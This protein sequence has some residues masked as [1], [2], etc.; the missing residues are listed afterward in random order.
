MGGKRG[1]VSSSWGEKDFNQSPE[2]KRVA[3]KGE[4]KKKTEY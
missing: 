2:G 3:E 4:K 1:R